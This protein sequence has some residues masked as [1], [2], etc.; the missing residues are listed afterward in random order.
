MAASDVA[1]LREGDPTPD[2]S[3]STRELISARRR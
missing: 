2:R 1:W 3:I